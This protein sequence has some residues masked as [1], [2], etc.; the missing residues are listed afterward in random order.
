MRVV[1]AKIQTI[2]EMYRLIWT[3]I[4]NKRPISAIYKELPRLFCPYR[5]ESFG[6]TRAHDFCSTKSALERHDNRAAHA[7][8]HTDT[9]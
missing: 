9:S 3:A 2:E 5:P 8:G 1:K 4:E 6:V 7:G